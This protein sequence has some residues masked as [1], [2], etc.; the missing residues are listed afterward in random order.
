ML[1]DYSL[2]PLNYKDKDPRGLPLLY[3]TTLNIT[4]Y[5]KQMQR[6][7]FYQ[8]LEVAETMAHRQGFLLLPYSCMNWKRACKFGQDRR[9]KIGR[10]SFILMK[11][12][13]LNKNEKSKLEYFLY[14]ELNKDI[15]VV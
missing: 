13:E 15:K 10:K 14:D 2:V 12:E 4:S 8:A 3:P 6:F 7:S 5:S 11:P 9:L 1:K